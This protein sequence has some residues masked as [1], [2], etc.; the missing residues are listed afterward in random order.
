MLIR[1]GCTFIGKEIRFYQ[2]HAAWS[3]NGSRLDSWDI[4]FLATSPPVGP[5]PTSPTSLTSPAPP[6]RESP[7]PQGPN[8]YVSLWLPLIYFILSLEILISFLS[9]L[10]FSFLGSLSFTFGP[11][12]LGRRRLIV[13]KTWFY[14]FQFRR[15]EFIEKVVSLTWK[16]NLSISMQIADASQKLPCILTFFEGPTALGYRCNTRRLE[17]SIAELKTNKIKIAFYYSIEFRSHCLSGCFSST[18][19][20]DMK[21]FDTGGFDATGSSTKFLTK[22]PEGCS[23][24][25]ARAKNR[26]CNSFAYR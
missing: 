24:E 12:I 18:S 5:S 15:G 2:P 4:C 10:P 7:P 22:S 6:T 26:P 8:F 11:G 17:P 21:F 23:Q 20:R 16:S 19:R 13:C 14:L 25:C 3:T 9:L 1:H